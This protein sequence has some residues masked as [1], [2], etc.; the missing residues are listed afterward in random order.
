MTQFI[1]SRHLDIKDDLKWRTGVIISDGHCIA[2][3]Y[4]GIRDNHIIV[5]IDGE[6]KSREKYRHVIEDTFRTLHSNF[7][8]LNV[9]QEICYTHPNSEIWLDYKLVIKHRELARPYY[10]MEL[11]EDITIEQ[12]HLLLDEFPPSTKLEEEMKTTKKIR[13]SLSCNRRRRRNGVHGIRR[14]S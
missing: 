12:I 3:V 2:K 13:A 7:P 1:V 9:K 6:V 14:Y 4:K 11:N 10:V 5:E 8:S